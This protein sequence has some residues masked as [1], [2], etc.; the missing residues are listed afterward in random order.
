M[1]QYNPWVILLGSKEHQAQKSA[2]NLNV[3]TFINLISQRFLDL[4]NWK[5]NVVKLHSISVI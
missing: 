3:C 2:L 1:F 5:R 4:L